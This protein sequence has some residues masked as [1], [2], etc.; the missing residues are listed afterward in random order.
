MKHKSMLDGQISYEN[1]ILNGGDVHYKEHK[2][3]DKYHKKR[4]FKRGKNDLK[5]D[6]KDMISSG[7]G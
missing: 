1:S 7:Y 4:K 2:S 5:S 6:R 3:G